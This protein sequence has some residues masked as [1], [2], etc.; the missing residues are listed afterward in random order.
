MAVLGATELRA[1]ASAA[2]RV[3]LV[4]AH[5]DDEYY[6]AATV[7][8]L[9]CFLFVNRWRSLLPQKPAKPGILWISD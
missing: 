5:P 1:V 9:R 7:W 3:L 2:P 8:R 4:V 6:C